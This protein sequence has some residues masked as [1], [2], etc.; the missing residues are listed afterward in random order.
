[1]HDGSWWSSRPS[2]GNQ[3]VIEIVYLLLEPMHLYPRIIQLFVH[4]D[5]SLEIF[6]PFKGISESQI[7]VGVVLVNSNRGL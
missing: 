6:G 2:L 1:L 4:I 3:H 5:S 7:G